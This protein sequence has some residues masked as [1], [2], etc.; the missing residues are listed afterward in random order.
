MAAHIESW[1]SARCLMQKEILNENTGRDSLHQNV[2]AWNARKKLLE[3]V[4]TTGL[5]S[6]AVQAF[7]YISCNLEGF[8]LV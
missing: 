8:F 7:E 3:N 4:F 1:A 5:S 2:F 6:I